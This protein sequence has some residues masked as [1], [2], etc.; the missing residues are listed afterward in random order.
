VW[1]RCRVDGQIRIFSV[2]DVNGMIQ[3]AFVYY[4]FIQKRIPDLVVKIIIKKILLRTTF[5]YRINRP[6]TGA[7]LLNNRINL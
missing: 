2:V 6:I 4:Y 1:L 5:Y 3:T 7:G